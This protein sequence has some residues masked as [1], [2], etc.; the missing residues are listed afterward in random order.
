M[1]PAQINQILTNLAVNARDAISGNGTVTIE[2][3]HLTVA[4][5]DTFEDLEIL[6]GRY[7]VISVSDDGCGMDKETRIRIFEP[8]FTT[9]PTGKGTGLGLSTVYGIVRQCN[10]FI[11]V[12]SEPGQGSTFRIYLPCCV[13]TEAASIAKKDP[14]TD[15]QRSETILVVERNNFV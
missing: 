2:T 4:E 3:S 1:D 9:K 13:E 8:F 14:G 12:Y 10:G 11:N 15:K 6:P 5:D 7:V